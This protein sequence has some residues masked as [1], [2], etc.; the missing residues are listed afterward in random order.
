MAITKDNVENVFTFHAPTEMDLQRCAA[1]RSTGL[2]FAEA[3]LENTVVCADQQ[4]AIRLVREAVMTA[5]MAV[6]LK[7]AV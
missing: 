2:A 5:T 1:I 7:G 4:A 3:I 6:A